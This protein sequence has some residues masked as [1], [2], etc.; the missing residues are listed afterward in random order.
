M[1]LR[2]TRYTKYLP[3]MQR[4]GCNGIWNAPN[5]LCIH[6]PMIFK[7]WSLL[8]TIL[9]LWMHQNPFSHS[10]SCCVLVILLPYSNMSSVLPTQSFELPSSPLPSFWTILTEKLNPRACLSSI[11]VAH[12]LPLDVAVPMIV[13]DILESPKKRKAALQ[14]LYD[15]TDQKHKEHR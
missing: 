5:G 6:V 15:L 1:A 13:A 8:P 10:S 7:V 12:D 11:D 4:A 9:E 3:P 14:Q 2:A